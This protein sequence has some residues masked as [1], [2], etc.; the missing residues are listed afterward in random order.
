MR[1]AHH[2]PEG[3]AQGGVEQPQGHPE[4]VAADEAGGFPGNG[5]EDHLEGLDQDEEARGARGPAA[6]RMDLI[7]LLVGAEA[8][9]YGIASWPHSEA[10]EVK[11]PE[12]RPARWLPGSPGATT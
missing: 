7:H 12:R 9:S 1:K 6:L 11:T 2:R 8:Q 5:G 10:A 3:Q 4:Q